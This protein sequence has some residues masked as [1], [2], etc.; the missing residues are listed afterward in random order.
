MSF[1]LCSCCPAEGSG[2]ERVV[3]TISKDKGKTWSTLVP[4]VPNAKVQYAYATIFFT[5]D[6]NVVYSIFVINSD[7]VTQLPS[8]QHISRTGL[9]EKTTSYV[10][11][12]HR[13]GN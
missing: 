3:S 6:P 9:C 5:V 4:L 10:V 11:D 1:G 12:R 7:N 13:F 2:L 8:G